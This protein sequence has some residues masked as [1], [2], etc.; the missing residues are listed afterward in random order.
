M[1]TLTFFPRVYGPEST[2]LLSIFSKRIRSLSEDLHL[3]HLEVNTNSRGHID[4]TINGEDE[5]FFRNVLEQRY[6]IVPEFETV[7]TD[8]EYPG[9]LIDVGN[10]GYGLY[11]DIGLP[12]NPPTDLL[13]PLHR[14]REQFNMPD[15]S[16]NEIKRKMVLVENLPVNTRI[17]KI[18]SRN[19]ELEGEFS[20]SYITQ[21]NTW[22][23]SSHQ[24]LLILGTTYKMIDN[25]LSKTDHKRDVVEIE[26]IGPFE[27]SVVCKIGTRATGILAAVGSRLRGIPIHPFIPEK[28]RG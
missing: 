6:G 2:H 28:V 9:Y 5:E 23:S 25:V 11:V 8:T 15:N 19:A 27:F 21:I 26:R 16:L 1:N 13:I 20:D 14:L 18:D 24:R 3:S 10:V 17:T 4:V 22:A 12:P 7:N